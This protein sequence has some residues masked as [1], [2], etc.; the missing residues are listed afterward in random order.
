MDTPHSETCGCAAGRGLNNGGGDIF[1]IGSI[2][3]GEVRME[4][5]P[6]IQKHADVVLYIEV[7]VQEQ[8]HERDAIKK[9]YGI[10][11]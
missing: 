1:S 10:P 6:R 9:A 2:R 4:T 11:D 3:S 5:T 7:R 8:E